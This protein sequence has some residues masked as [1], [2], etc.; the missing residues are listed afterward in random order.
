MHDIQPHTA[1]AMP[2]LL[3][4]LKA[5][6]Y[7]VSAAHRDGRRSGWQFAPVRSMNEHAA[8]HADCSVGP[9]R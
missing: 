1:A 9:A 4:E 5:K 3:K 8:G 6:G 7:K 2:D